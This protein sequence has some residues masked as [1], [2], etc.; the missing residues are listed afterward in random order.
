MINKILT[1]FRENFSRHKILFSIGIG[2]LL[3]AACVGGYY[4]WGWYQH[5]QSAA[6]AME[7]LQRALNPP[8]VETL[9]HMVDFRAISHDLAQILASVFPFYHAGPDQERLIRHRL[10]QALLQRLSDK[11]KQPAY[12][13]EGNEEKDLQKPLLILPGNFLEQLVANM[14]LR[15]TGPDSALLT[16]KIENPQ[17]EHAIAP[18]FRMHKTQ[19]GW[20]V[21]KLINASEIVAVLRQDLL[22]R[23]ARL[24]EVFKA[25]NENTRKKMDQL[26]P[27]LSC[28]A[29]G[30]LLSDGK[31]FILMIHVIARNRGDIQANNYSLDVSISGKNGKTIERRFLNAAKPVAPGEDFNHRWSFELE[32][33]SSL[34][35]ALMSEIPLQ[36]KASWQT[37][38]LSNAQV[39]HIEEVPNPD[40]ACRI[41]GHDHPEGFCVIP[42]FLP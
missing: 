3:A 24:R 9:A 10:Q 7:K 40:R 21:G 31:T 13:A 12:V 1:S 5:R 28:S 18:V 4:G 2:V 38:G 25:K 27:I 34:A 17:L 16:S 33:Q 19:D 15:E 39:W 37:L 22:K 32:S 42:V 30:G 20:V 14:S 41:K 35:Q 29:D 26:L 11:D 23:H 36:C 6:Y 8:D